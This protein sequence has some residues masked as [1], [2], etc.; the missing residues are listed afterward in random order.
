MDAIQDLRSILKPLKQQ[1]SSVMPSY[2]TPLKVGV[3]G[4]CKTTDVGFP[5]IE[6]L[7]EDMFSKVC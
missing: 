5:A 6:E 3:H 1:R 7:E 4:L 2:V